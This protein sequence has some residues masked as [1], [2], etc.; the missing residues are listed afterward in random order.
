MIGREGITRDT[1][2]SSSSL[3]LKDIELGKKIGSGASAIVNLGVHRPTGLVLAVKS[4]NAYDTEKRRQLM[5]DIKALENSE[6]AFLVKYYGA[7][8]DEGSCRLVLEFMDAGSL[9]DLIK[10]NPIVP[11]G[12]IALI[13]QQVLMGLM[14]LHRVKRQMH[15]DIKPENV[16]VNSAGAVKLSDFGISKELSA[17]DELCKTFVGTRNYMSPERISGKSYSY[18]GDIW[19]LG[20]MLMQM[21]LGRFPYPDCSGVIELLDAMLQ[22]PEPTLPSSFTP[23]FQDFIRRCVRLEPNERW[24]AIAL[25]AHPWI[26]SSQWRKV[27][28]GSWIRR[29]KRS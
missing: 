5:K 10:K 7:Y 18:A 15:R 1:S 24:T 11:E 8:Y 14:Y 2:V 3:S 20:L 16:L 23:E 13:A 4:I 21:A 25:A 6:C 26:L 28:L 22:M 17:T 27:D 19:G 9:A 12:V 29:A